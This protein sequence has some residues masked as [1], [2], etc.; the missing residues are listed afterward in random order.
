MMKLHPA[1]IE[2]QRQVQSARDSLK[3]IAGAIQ[4]ECP[5]E[6]AYR[7]P[8]GNPFTYIDSYW[9]EVRACPR[10]GL[11]EEGRWGTFKQIKTENLISKGFDWSPWG[12]EVD[13]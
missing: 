9:Q 12:F 13:G 3:R 6:V 11:V 2:A 4:R 5:H 10:C 8:A 1:I 7:R